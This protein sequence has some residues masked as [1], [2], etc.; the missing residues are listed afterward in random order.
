MTKSQDNL[1]FFFY[2]ESKPPQKISFYIMLLYANGHGLYG[3]YSVH[4]TR[5]DQQNKWENYAYCICQIFAQKHQS[6]RNPSSMMI[7]IMQPSKKFKRQVQGQNSIF[8]YVIFFVCVLVHTHNTTQLITGNVKTILVLVI[9][10]S[11][12]YLHDLMW[13]HTSLYLFCIYMSLHTYNHFSFLI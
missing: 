6:R 3:M 4:R 10:I 13:L 7:N 11:C 12:S 2:Q 5:L 9:D 1:T 8:L